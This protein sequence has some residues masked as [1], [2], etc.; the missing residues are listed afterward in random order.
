MKR[1]VVLILLIF[2]LCVISVIGYRSLHNRITVVESDS[3]AWVIPFHTVE[4]LEQDP[5]LDLII[6][7]TVS[8]N[9][10][11]RLIV[12]NISSD[13]PMQYWVMETD[14]RIDEVIRTHG[15]I[16]DRD[17]IKVLEPTYIVENS[18][19]FD[20]GKTEYPLNHYLKAAPGGKYIFYLAWNDKQKAYWVYADYQ[21]K[22][23]I[24]G[25]D[26]R[27]VNLEQ[28]NSRYQS[29]KES[30]LDKYVK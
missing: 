13:P 14:V 30:V 24:D 25:R 11:P 27:E 7:G 8:S 4:G 22:Y 10:N 12:G 1:N 26:K 28:T 23:N 9:T 2:A 21:G 29:L 18:N 3:R 5:N 17:M 15:N 19:V 16:K 6:K 20:P